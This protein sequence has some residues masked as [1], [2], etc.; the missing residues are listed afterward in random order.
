MLS[1]LAQC[2]YPGGPRTPVTRDGDIRLKVCDTNAVLAS[3]GHPPI[4]GDTGTTLVSR[5]VGISKRSAR[6]SD[7]FAVLGSRHAES[8]SRSK[9]LPAGTG[10]RPTVVFLSCGPARHR[11]QAS[12]RPPHSHY[13]RPPWRPSLKKESPMLPFLLDDVARLH[14]DDMVRESDAKLLIRQAMQDQP[15][16][17]LNRRLRSR[18]G[19]FFI[20][21]GAFLA[22]TGTAAPGATLDNASS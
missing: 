3:W 13:G 2:S 15:S 8:G 12:P 21:V 16:R 1:H 7:A 20:A 22:Q 14:H 18:A 11:T 17:S 9:W 5:L 4:S 6:P 10:S 19:Q